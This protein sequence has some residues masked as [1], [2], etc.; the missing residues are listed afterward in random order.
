MY[1]KF[2]ASHIFNGKEFL[3]PGLAI[4]TDEA[5][6]ILEI[7]TAGENDER[8]EG[9]LMPGMV[10]CHCHT[11]LSHLKGMIPPHTGLVDFVQQVL[12][13][14]YQPQEEIHAAITHAIEEMQQQGIVAVGDI[15]NTALSASHKKSGTI[16]WRN[17]VEV[18]GFVD[19]TAL[20]RWQ[21]A[22]SLAG[23]FDDAYVVPH[24]SYSVSAALFRLINQGN[25]KRI[26]IHNQETQA[27]DMLWKQGTGDF[28]KLYQNLGI[29][30]R[31]FEPSGKTSLQTWLP[32]FTHEQPIV[33][34]HNTFTSEEDL[35]FAAASAHEI[36]YCICINANIYIEQSLPPIDT[37]MRNRCA[38]VLGTDSLASNS[39]LSILEEMRTIQH[40]FPHIPLANLLQ[41]ATFNGAKALGFDKLGSF[42][43]GKKPGVLCVR[44]VQGDVIAAQ[45]TVER[46]I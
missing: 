31:A 43:K 21:E 29:E 41:W 4:L 33:A 10:N 24:A 22:S 42:E 17:F 18:S 20:Q 37:F 9:M 16:A 2:T 38:V 28:L 27:E 7:T 35:K 13:F 34:V 14:R 32:H 30:L 39:Q 5:G 44:G 26:S 23:A 19:A 12:A 1:R 25:Q 15:C 8:Y 40:H 11:E 46:L 3:E 36:Y 45:T 6:E